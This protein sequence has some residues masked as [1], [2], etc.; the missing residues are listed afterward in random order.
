MDKGGRA[1]GSRCVVKLDPLLFEDCV[2]EKTST[3]T[4]A[5]SATCSHA[6]FLLPGVGRARG[7]LLQVPHRRMGGCPSRASA[8]VPPLAHLVVW[9][10][11]AGDGATARTRPP[12]IRFMVSHS[13]VCVH[14]FCCCCSLCPFS[15]RWIIHVEFGLFVLSFGV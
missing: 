7:F 15:R 3:S 8:R 10:G 12:G 9:C 6:G 13:Q 1:P 14:V 5:T 4:P 11:S 2:H